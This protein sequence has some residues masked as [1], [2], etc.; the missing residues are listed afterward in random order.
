VVCCVHDAKD[1]ELLIMYIAYRLYVEVIY[2]YGMEF[3]FHIGIIT[4]ISERVYLV[5]I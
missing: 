3:S 4:A 2:F 1:I 5:D